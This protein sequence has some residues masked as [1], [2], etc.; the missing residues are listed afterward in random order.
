VLREGLHLLVLL[1]AIAG[2]VLFLWLTSEKR[3][4]TA[5][6]YTTVLP[7]PPPGTPPA[8]CGPVTLDGRPFVIDMLYSVEK[9][10]WIEEAAELFARRCPN[11]E[12]RLTPAGDIEGADAILRGDA[13]PTV[14]SPSDETIVAYLEH[15][16][17]ASGG[18]PLF[19]DASVSLVR[20]PLVILMWE[21]RRRV[22]AEI[23]AR[24]ANQ[25]MWSQ[26][27]CAMIPPD[28]PVD[29]V[30]LEDRVPGL[31]IDWYRQV[32]GAPE[33]RADPPR[34]GQRAPEPAPEPELAPTS[35]APL[36]GPAE[37]A[38]WDWVQIGHS[39]PTHTAA[40][41]ETLYLM[42]F[43]HL[44]P[45]DARPAAGAPVS[46]EFP[47]GPAVRGD[48]LAAP[49]AAAL[50]ERSEPLRKW[51]ARCEGGLEGDPP[52]TQLLTETMFHLGEALYDG[53][54][55]Y[56]HR[57]F[58]ALERLDGNADVMQKM[59]VVYPPVT[60]VNRHPALIAIDAGELRV[61]AARRWLEFL[62]EEAMQRR[63]IELGFR[64]ANPEVEIREYHVE[65]NPF[66]R[67]RR[68]GVQFTAPIVE[69][70]RLGGER[71]V[72]LLEPWRDATGRN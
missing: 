38:G 66:L 30:A 35:K 65:A 9:Q 64:P 16:R 37:I 21:E 3:A 24:T 6:L 60:F 29:T 68:F 53:V 70:P 11:I 36:P 54:A 27:L 45:P 43:D 46:D 41:L 33:R 44:L 12:V 5:P 28:P 49:F 22:Y 32:V 42:A 57:V 69:P 34:P 26:L 50:D 17:R 58:P 59:T 56:E 4:T 8:D 10:A 51:F 48:H 55:T 62:R 47:E 40:G 31:W 1:L 72:Q 52:S 25:G 71:I 7:P 20:S 13:A 63:A 14:W 39:S 61:L 67:F 19:A 15:R 23:R 18:T 2:V